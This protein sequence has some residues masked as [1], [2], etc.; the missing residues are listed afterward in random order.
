MYF[1]LLF[2]LLEQPEL[3]PCVPQTGSSKGCACQGK[4]VLQLLLWVAGEGWEGWPHLVLSHN[5]CRRHPACP[6]L[7]GE[8]LSPAHAAIPDNAWSNHF[9]HFTTPFTENLWNKKSNSFL[10]LKPFQVGSIK[11]LKTSFLRLQSINR[12]FTLPYGIYKQ[13]CK[14]CTKLEMTY[15]R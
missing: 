12:S 11:N 7:H 8:C 2:A 5:P 14:P 1:G 4:S 10:L 13:K 6:A 15:M 9:L 3:T